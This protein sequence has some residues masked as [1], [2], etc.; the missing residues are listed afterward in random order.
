MT[1]R[2]KDHGAE[3]LIRRMGHKAVLRVGVIGSEAAAKKDVRAAGSS[4]ISTDETVASVASAHEFGLGVPKRSF[5][6]GYVDESEERIK[7]R[8]RASAEKVLKGADLKT[9]IGLLGAEIQGGIQ[10][11]ISSG[12]A[13]PLSDARREQKGSSVPLIDTGQ[14]R[15]SVTWDAEV[16]RG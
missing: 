12:I 7:A 2:E 1:V 15:S 4:I 10:E 13:P 6:A 5:I 14:L 8:L 11:R 16:R 3:A 9:E